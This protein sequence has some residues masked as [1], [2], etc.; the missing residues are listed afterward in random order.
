MLSSVGSWIFVGTAIVL[1]A[2]A[3]SLGGEVIVLTL[4]AALLMPIVLIVLAGEIGRR[5]S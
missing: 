5:S 1:L 2:L 4:V 3:A